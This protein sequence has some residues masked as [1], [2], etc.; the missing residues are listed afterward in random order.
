MKRDAMPI[1]APHLMAI[2]P[3]PAQV[4][5][6]G[7]GAW[8]WDA[9]GTRYL[10][11][12]QGWAVNLL[13]HCPPE[14]TQALHAQ[15]GQLITPSPALHNAPAIELGKRK[16]WQRRADRRQR[17]FSLQKTALA[18]AKAEEQDHYHRAHD[19]LSV[20]EHAIPK[21]PPVSLTPRFCCGRSNKIRAQRA[22]QGRP[23]VASNVIP[24]GWGAP[25]EPNVLADA[26][27]GRSES[28]SCSS[29][30]QELAET[31][32]PESC[33]STCPYPRLLP[34]VV[35]PRPRTPR[36]YGSSSDAAI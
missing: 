1:P 33:L 28:E 30:H 22:I 24:R 29:A 16:H 3:R 27:H 25:G 35:A 9:A 15:A 7:Q 2:N 14:L 36:L 23:S 8:L 26:S 18:S 31:S 20:A 17:L 11:W 4:F 6:R 13:G 32:E 34:S 10:D 12:L 19:N 5:V 21:S